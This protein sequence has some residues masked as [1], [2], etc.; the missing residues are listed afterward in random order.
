MNSL[1]ASAFT[2]A[3]TRVFLDVF[4]GGHEIDMKAAM[5]WIMSQYEG[6]KNVK[7]TG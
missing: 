1:S 5:Y 4:D 7:V 2:R 6:L 3:F